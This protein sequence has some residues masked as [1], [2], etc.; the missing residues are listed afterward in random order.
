MTIVTEVQ[1][2]VVPIPKSTRKNRI[3]ENIDIFDFELS[4]EEMDTLRKF[5]KNYRTVFPSFWQDHPYY[6]YE[7][8][9]V[10]DPDPFKGNH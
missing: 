8:K 5:N 9:D 6:P 10:P 3:E 4:N 2:G 7:K 1:L